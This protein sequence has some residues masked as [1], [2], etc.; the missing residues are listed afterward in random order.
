VVLKRPLARID[1]VLGGSEA[2]MRKYFGTWAMLLA[3]FVS[4][5]VV[6]RPALAVSPPQDQAKTTY[7]IPEYNAYQAASAEKDPQAKIKLL[8]DFVTKFPNSTLLPYV[9]QV[10]YQ[11]YFQ[12]KNYPKTIE[13]ADKLAALGDKVDQGTRLSALYQRTLAFNFVFNE[14]APDATVQEQKAKKAADEGLSVLNAIPK[15]ANLTDAQFADQKKGPTVLFDYTSG[16]TAYHLKDYPAAIEKLKAALALSP[17]DGVS[18]YRL[19]L[20][21]VASNPAQW[22]DGFWALARAVDL[23]VSGADQIKTYLRKQMS[24]YEQPN[25]DNLVDAQFNELLQLAANSPERPA[26]WSIPSVADL[27]KITTGSTIVTVIT[28]LKAGGDKAKMTW[29]AICGAEFPEVVGKVIEVTPGADSVVI[30]A[31]TGATPEEMQSAT[32]ANMEVKVEGQPE[33]SRIQKDDGVRFSGTLTGYDPEPFKLHWEKAKVNAE[34]I[35]AEK[36]SKHTP[37][38]LPA[39]PGK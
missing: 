15:P 4:L 8:D 20:A 27:Q 39:K 29:L 31:Y 28:D 10:Y 9:Y 33:A 24:N 12:L 23:K 25:C 5:S 6:A 1:P 34:D 16:L 36:G 38:K 18:S 30:R 35:P 19:G 14:K 13:S 26:T 2:M 32:T 3:L 11:A 17:D 37:H 22:L 21:Y 7:T